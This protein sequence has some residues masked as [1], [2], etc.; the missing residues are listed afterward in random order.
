MDRPRVYISGP[1]T[2]GDRN[3]NYFQAVDAERKLMLAGFAPLNPMRS[4]TLP[5]AWQ[6]DM[7]HDLWL[8]VDLQW[9][10]CAEAVYRLPGES[11]GADIECDHAEARGIPVFCSFK[12]LEAW[13]DNRRTAE[14]A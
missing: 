8:Q 5:F 7:P 4:M 6:D 12:S 2:K 1:I 10:E 13:R 14:V 9:V 11:K 3:V